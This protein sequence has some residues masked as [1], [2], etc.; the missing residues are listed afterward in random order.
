[1]TVELS[2]KDAGAY[3]TPDPVVAS[4]LKWVV[5]AEEDR[6]LDPSCGDGR[7]IAGHRNSVGIEQDAQA[8]QTAMSRAPWALVHEGEFFAWASE[9]QHGAD[10]MTNATSR[11]YL[12]TLRLA[13]Q[14]YRSR[15]SDL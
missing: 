12:R 3:Y 15:R 7:F 9:D 5:R 4:L 6:L 1:V 13:H 11:S 2:Q 8:T 14:Q 10:G